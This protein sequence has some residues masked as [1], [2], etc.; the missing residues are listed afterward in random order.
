MMRITYDPIAD[1]HNWL[2]IKEKYPDNFTTTPFY[3]FD[4][5]VVLAKGNLDDIAV[6]IDSSTIIKFNNQALALKKAWDQIERQVLQAIGDYLGTELVMFDVKVNLTTAYLMPYDEQDNWFMIP[7]H[8][9][10]VKQLRC[11][12]HELFHLYQ[13]KINPKLLQEER[14]AEVHK[15]LRG[16]KFP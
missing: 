6:T 8:K 2:R 9:P 1:L 4:K 13:T 14:E 10:L 7:T 11:I 12:A 5:T 3:P 16:L 15:F